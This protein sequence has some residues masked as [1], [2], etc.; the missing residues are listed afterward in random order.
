MPGGMG[1]PGGSG[2]GGSG[3]S[4]APA[5]LTTVRVIVSTTDGKKS[6]AY[7][8]IPTTSNTER[9]WR[10]VAIP[11]QAINGFERTNKIVK[12]ITFSG[13]VTTTFFVGDVRVVDDATTIRGEIY[14]ARRSYNLALGDRLTLTGNGQGGASVLE[15]VW[16][17]DASD[18]LQEDAVGQTVVHQFRNAG[19]D[20]KSRKFTVTLTIRDK[21]GLK[22]SATATTEVVVNP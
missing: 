14:N 8:P 6:E 2:M 12:D 20:N 10:T 21:Y 5:P 7:M 11:L 9:G 3:A 15:Y 19:L 13:D 17:F 4:T 22:P 1:T 18:G 16:D